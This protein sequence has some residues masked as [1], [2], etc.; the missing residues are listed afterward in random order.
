[1]KAGQPVIVLYIFEFIYDDAVS[2][3]LLETKYG[4]IYYQAV[5]HFSVGTGARKKFKIFN[6][7]VGLIGRTVLFCENI[8][9]I[10]CLGWGLLDNVVNYFFCELTLTIVEEDQFEAF[11]NCG[12]EIVHA[13]SVVDEELKRVTLVENVPL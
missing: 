3:L 1:M 9:E 4:V 6:I 13:R 11:G 2:D 12:Q 8:A 10:I 5:L 7:V